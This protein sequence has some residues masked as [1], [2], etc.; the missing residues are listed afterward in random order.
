MRFL[1]IGAK[2]DSLKTAT[3]YSEDVLDFIEA[4]PSQELSS[5][6]AKKDGLGLVLS[7]FSDENSG[8]LLQNVH[9]NTTLDAIAFDL[10]Y[11]ETP[12]EA[13][14]VLDQVA[15]YDCIVYSTWSHTP[16][17]PRYRVVFALATQLEVG[18]RNDHYAKFYKALGKQLKFPDFDSSCSQLNRIFFLPQHQPGVQP[19]KLRFS[20]KKLS[21]SELWETLP[22]KTK[23]L[24]K[25]RQGV[26]QLRPT[27]AA[28]NKLAS[29]L[30]ANGGAFGEA[31][32]ML[33]AVMDGRPYVEAHS[34]QVHNCTLSLAFVLAKKLPEL[35][36]A[37][38]AEEWLDPVWA[39]LWPGEDLAPIHQDWDQAWR[40]AKTKVLEE[41][42][43]YAAKLQSLENN[44]PKRTLSD[45]Q[46]QAALDCRYR[47]AVMFGN[48]VYVYDALRGQYREP[49]ADGSLQMRLTECVGQVP[50]VDSKLTK[51]VTKDGRGEQVPVSNAQL[52]A[53]CGICADE[54]KY[55]GWDPGRTYD[56]DYATL[57]VQAYRTREGIEPVYH[58]HVDD[59][60]ES[61]AGSRK[62]ELERWL[63][64]C[65]D[66]RT[67][68]PALV[69]VGPKGTYKST[70]S[71]RVAQF[72]GTAPCSAHSVMGKQH[73]DDVLKC[74][75]IHTDEALPAKATP[76][77]YREMITAR[78]H[79]I[80][81]KYLAPVQ[82]NS[83][84]RHVISLND[85]RELYP[86]ELEPDAAEATMAR[87]L[88]IK[89]DEGRADRWRER[90]SYEER[91]QVVY[92]WA[93]N[94]HIAW[95]EQNRDYQ[96]EDDRFWMK[97]NNSPEVLT[98]INLGG[99]TLG[100]LLSQAVAAIRETAEMPAATEAHL[101]ELPMV[102]RS[103][104]E[105][106][107]YSPAKAHKWWLR[108][109]QKG[110]DTDFET[111]LRPIQIGKHT[112]PLTVQKGRQSLS[113]KGVGR[114][115]D[116]GLV[117]AW[118]E[119]NEEE[120]AIKDLHDLCCKLWPRT[121]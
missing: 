71:N 93:I 24:R 68:I 98:E 58:P 51:W 90:W 56:D 44:R 102:W 118:L 113:L 84:L 38:F 48:R 50:G 33:S 39:K 87:Y 88:I 92:G 3:F 27:K 64:K 31:G 73:K 86:K 11:F 63:F 114:G 85:E 82:L 23:D 96:R 28:L 74:P 119:L 4:T 10:D 95:L 19:I 59:L 110:R 62:E 30:S 97:V 13:A 57:H 103:E 77:E 78:E 94:E 101:E 80:E 20:G 52:K 15:Q 61:I 120:V 37:W 79:K 106:L 65:R 29:S 121:E 53:W 45:D 104:Q 43:E 49:V 70:M 36:D 91:E 9:P 35:D 6:K 83:Y 25:S 116:T 69:L 76:A 89:T 22:E 34:G 107:R 12:E 40:S 112:R 81:Q 75:V 117:A 47:W 99:A 42:T 105:G 54:V 109:R 108:L 17:M 60:L 46:I 7:Q 100:K 115:L 2:S 72:W 55:W 14:A 66:L 111:I 41:R 21:V 8:R 18:A 16:A 32:L 1:T 67:G 5:R 26:A